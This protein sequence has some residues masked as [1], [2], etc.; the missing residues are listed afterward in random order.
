ML[1]V[2]LELPDLTHERTVE[3]FRDWNGDP[4]YLHL[5]Q[6][7]RV[8]SADPSVAPVIR[9]GLQERTAIA[10][11]KVDAK[12]QQSDADQMDMDEDAALDLLPALPAEA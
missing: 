7:I 11:S 4:A 3:L 10:K 8:S 12:T 5:L 9:H 6:F 2:H 1:L